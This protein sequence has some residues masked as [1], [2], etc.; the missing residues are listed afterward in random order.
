MHKIPNIVKGGTMPAQGYVRFPT[1]YQSSIVLVS[2]DDLWLVSS[3]GGRAE[4]LTAGVGR[5]SY[6]RLSPDGQ[7]LA[8][9]GREEGPGEIYMMPALGGPAQRLTFQGDSSCRVLGWSPQ[10]DAILYTSSAG[11]FDTDYK[12]IYAISLKG[13]LPRQL[14]F[15]IANAI[16][17]GPCGGIVLGRNIEE[18][19]YWK[20]YRGGRVGHLWCDNDGS[21]TFQRLLDLAGNLADPCWVGDRIYFISD[22]EGVGNIY[23]C[24]PH[25]ED[26]CRHTER[27]DFYVR[28]LSTDGQRLVFQA[29]AD[30]YLFDPQTDEVRQVD[31][32]FPSQRT[33]LNRKFV[34]AEAYLDTV[35]LHPQGLG[36]ALTTRGKAFSMSNWEGAVLQHGELDGVR[37]RFLEWL[38]DGKR[39]VAVCDAAGRE[40][41]V[42]FDPYSDSER[43]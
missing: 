24:T 19:A 31:V 8:F 16:S 42:I 17:Y 21:G 14:P 12:V 7:C 18:P 36:I 1:L 40:T 5:A 26:L 35:A 15:G 10:G 28:Y 33:Q 34:A 41:L 32:S 4:R 39:L 27:N 29:A 6:P 22:H 25:G 20:R 43:R 23:S 2:E 37:Y 11:Q 30:L 9:V 13:G 3:S 38:N